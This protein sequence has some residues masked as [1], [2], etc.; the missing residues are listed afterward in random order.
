M[1]R[2]MPCVHHIFRY[3][4]IFI[5]ESTHKIDDE[6][7][8]LPTCT[9]SVHLY[10]YVFCNKKILHIDN[11]TSKLY[12]LTHSRWCPRHSCIF[13]RILFHFCFF[14]GP[15]SHS[16]VFLFVI[17]ITLTSD[18]IFDFHKFSFNCATR[19]THSFSLSI[20]LSFTLS[21][22]FESYCFC[23][24]HTYQAFASRATLVIVH[25]HVL[26]VH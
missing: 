4:T 11:C 16:L 2:I 8:G 5:A 10:F 14:S 13:Y 24:V 15:S 18:Y 6:I 23:H 22:S 20:C 19:I 9:S 7:R 21:I 12:S 1:F 26:R 25:A 3:I 17:C